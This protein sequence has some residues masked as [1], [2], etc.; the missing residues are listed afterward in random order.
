VGLSTANPLQVRAIAWAKV[1]TDKIDAA[2]LARLHAA[3]FLPG[4][5]MPTEEVEL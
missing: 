2:V 1:K 3:Q 4:V 5:R